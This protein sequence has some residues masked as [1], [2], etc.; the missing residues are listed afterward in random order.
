MPRTLWPLFF[1][2]TITLSIVRDIKE[3]R[4]ISHHYKIFDFTVTHSQKNH[5]DTK[6]HT[7]TNCPQNADPVNCSQ[8]LGSNSPHS[9][10][11]WK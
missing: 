4:S 8:L 9:R 3:Q 2:D 5:T 6:N 7:E 1:P 10:G 11:P